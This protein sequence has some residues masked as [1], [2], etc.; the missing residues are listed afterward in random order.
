MIDDT[1]STIMMYPS[2]KQ[3]SIGDKNVSGINIASNGTAFAPNTIQIGNANSRINMN[4]LSISRNGTVLTS[5][6]GSVM[7]FLGEN[8]PDGWVICNGV[9]RTNN[10]DGRY[11]TLNTLGIGTGGNGVTNYTPPDFRGS[12]LRG[13]GTSA[14]NSLYVGPSLTK[15]GGTPTTYQNMGVLQH[16]H[17]V[18]DPS[19]RHNTAATDNGGILDTTTSQGANT[20]VQDGYPTGYSTTGITIETSSVNTPSPYSNTETRPFNCGVNWILKI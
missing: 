16:G 14:V 3:I 4:G 11:N 8:D 20:Y 10:S 1:N 18:T 19:H 2:N 15:N 5:P 12:F 13:T 6:S 9:T 17:T 7:A